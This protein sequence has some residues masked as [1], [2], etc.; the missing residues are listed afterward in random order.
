MIT[1]RHVSNTIR[2]DLKGSSLTAGSKLHEV[3]IV[4][5]FIAAY[6]TCVL[7]HINYILF[8]PGSGKQTGP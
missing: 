3:Y 7:M 6:S 4:H 2:W 1:K 5:K 8:C